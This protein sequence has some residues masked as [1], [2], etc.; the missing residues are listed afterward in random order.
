MIL[1]IK[2]ETMDRTLWGTLFGRG[3][4]SVERQITELISDGMNEQHI[5]VRLIIKQKYKDETD[6]HTYV[7]LSCCYSANHYQKKYRLGNYTF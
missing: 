6:R 2:E 7:R 3:Y 1:D 4:G 5:A